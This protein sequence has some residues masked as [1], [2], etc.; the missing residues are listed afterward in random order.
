MRG[1][2]L[3]EE[4]DEVTLELDSATVN[5]NLE[6]NDEGLLT[7]NNDS[8]YLKSDKTISDNIQFL[9]NMVFSPVWLQ[10]FVLTFAAEWGDRSQIATVALA[11]ANN[12]WWVTIGGILGHATCSFAAV[13]GGRMVYFI[14]FTIF[15][16]RKEYQ[17]SM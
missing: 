8:S 4:L 11:G 2:E 9:L 10:A 12:F 15:S 6:M 14:I 17:L 16:L 3:Q 1:D 7:P 5:K 13:L